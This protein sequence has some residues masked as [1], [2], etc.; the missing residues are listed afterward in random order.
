[1][2]RFGRAAA[3]GAVAA[4]A[5]AGCSSGGMASFGK[6][7]EVEDPNAFPTRYK[8]EVSQ[9]MRTYLANPTKVRDAYI[10]EPALKPVAG[11]S[12]YVSCVRYNPRNADESYQGVQ[13]N[14]AIFFGGN[15]TQFLQPTPELCGR[16]PA[17]Q[18]FPELEVLVP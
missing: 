8:M 4:I 13:E 9:Y 14:V 17:Y 3:L 2:L 5:L 6:K 10:T 12:R 16:N 1:M 18:R 7:E 15:I 11:T